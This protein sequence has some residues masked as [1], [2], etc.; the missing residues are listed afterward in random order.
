MG[1][2]DREQR[3]RE[4]LI[5]AFAPRELTIVDESHRHVGHAGAA[6][7]GG[8]FRI[9]IVAD[10]FAGLAP[11]ARHRRVYAALGD[12]MTGEIHA[13]SIDARASDGP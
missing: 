1:T 7:G 6:G 2:T 4:R 8:H 13:L 9:R 5:A 10:A 11:V 12:L 3:L